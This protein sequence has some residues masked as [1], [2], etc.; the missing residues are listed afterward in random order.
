MRRQLWDLGILDFLIGE[1]RFESDHPVV[2]P[3]AAQQKS[4][5]PAAQHTPTCHINA[6]SRCPPGSSTVSPSRRSKP[7]V[8][9]NRPHSATPAVTAAFG[10]GTSST[11]PVR[12][13][14]AVSTPSPSKRVPVAA[15]H[16][17]EPSPDRG[18]LLH[19]PVS[20]PTSSSA[21]N[22]N[23]AP[24]RRAL[25]LVPSPSANRAS[26][27]AAKAITG[28][29]RAPS[30]LPVNGPLNPLPSQFSSRQM[31]DDESP[32]KIQTEYLLQ[33]RRSL[34]H[35]CD[36]NRP[37]G[38][39]ESRPGTRDATFGGL[40][41]PNGFVPT[42][43]V[44]EDVAALIA[45][46]DAEE[47]QCNENESLYTSSD[48][49]EPTQ[50]SALSLTHASLASRRPAALKG[51]N[52]AGSSARKDV[53]PIALPSEPESDSVDQEK[54]KQRIYRH[55][56]RH[57]LMV[58]L[59]LE[60]LVSESGEMDQAYC[61]T[62]LSDEQNV[63]IVQKHLSSAFN[64][65][66][67][68]PLSDWAHKAG[69]PTA[70]LLRLACRFLFDANIYQDRHHIAGGAFSQVHACRSIKRQSDSA[71]LALKV[72][73]IPSRSDNQR[74]QLI[75]FTEVGIMHRL[76]NIPGVC[77]LHDYGIDQDHIYL[78]MTKYSCCLRDWREKQKSDPSRQL[79]LYLNIFCQL[80]ELVQE[81][82][83]EGVVHF[84]LKGHNILLEKLPCAKEEDFWQPSTDQPPFKVVLADFGDSCDF[85]LS[86][87]QLTARSLGTE[88]NRSPEMLTTSQGRAVQNGAGHVAGSSYPSD[89]WALG[90]LL[91]EL[92]TQQLLFQ[93]YGNDYP[94]F[95]AVVTGMFGEVLLSP[96]RL[97]PVEHMPA[98]VD[99]LSYIL[100]RDITRRP[101]T[102]DIVARVKSLVQ[103]V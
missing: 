31:S 74:T 55:V 14:K 60:L 8:S 90:C 15:E 88:I 103:T 85:S 32:T 6:Y 9:L 19:V 11:S 1:M 56:E 34:D 27:S 76:R 3:F 48:D 16:N 79:N 41:A 40:N 29:N 65:D 35:Y 38:V 44:N 61:A 97:R 46:E 86:D 20:A 100:Q 7:T 81:V 78:V 12:V 37:L 26:P 18:D 83:K 66:L 82:H 25:S 87:E 5:A 67:A 13:G 52:I 23:P 21:A 64:A 36:E 71:Q 24:V 58:Q 69:E 75:A 39:P 17:A 42:G 89:V 4:A 80:V 59:A 54:P 43:D 33:P 101:T 70:R 57:L 45:L 96:E 63:S 50:P 93:E 72:S 53:T 49:E 30:L 2:L 22:A 94:K 95:H 73:E 92:L 62:D 47:A 28:T 68:G 77:K 84:D 91:Y 51:L 102:S 98:I 10:A 99:L